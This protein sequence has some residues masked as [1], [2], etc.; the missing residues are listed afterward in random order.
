[1]LLALSRLRIPLLGTREEGVAA[2]DAA[3]PFGQW[4]CKPGA[5]EKEKAN[6]DVPLQQDGVIPHLH[7]WSKQ[8]LHFNSKIP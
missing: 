4:L 2:G 5:K 6:C 8:W 7:L 1:M 3:A